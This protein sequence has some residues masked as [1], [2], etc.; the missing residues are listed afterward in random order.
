MNTVLVYRLDQE[1]K[2]KIPLGI[3]VDRRKS[4]R[5]DNVIGML[6]LARKEFAKSE[7]ESSQIFISYE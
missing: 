2:G 1:T 3:L 6:R 4:D 5:G 7:E